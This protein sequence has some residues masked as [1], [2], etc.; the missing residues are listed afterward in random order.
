MKSKITGHASVKIKAP[1][2][3]VWEALTDPAIIKKWFYGTNT[4]TSWKPGT[5]ITF[6]GTWEGK[7]YIDKGTIIDV[8]PHTLIQY[9]Y[10][11]SL[12]GIEDLPE[13]YVTITYE[14]TGKNDETKLNITQEN[15]PDE[16]MK[17]HSEANWTEV[18]SKLK[19]LLEKQMVSSL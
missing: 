15:I 17:K 6:E 3:K 13:N 8:R 7:S 16:K 19:N 14:L 12:S 9:S 18:L 1:A 5:P 4:K 11:S 10:W 2:S